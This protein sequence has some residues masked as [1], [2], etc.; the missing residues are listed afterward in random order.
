MKILTGVAYFHIYKIVILKLENVNNVTF[1]LK[2]PTIVSGKAQKA[3]AAYFTS[4]HI[5]IYI[6]LLFKAKRQFIL[7]FGFEEQYYVW[8]VIVYLTDLY[9]NHIRHI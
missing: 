5:I 2:I 7:L 8:Y 6:I 9:I 3:V 1:K 4:N